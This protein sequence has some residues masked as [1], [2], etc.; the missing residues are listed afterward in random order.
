VVQ[1]D[2]FA[3]AA[4]A[5]RERAFLV[6]LATA[7][8]RREEAD[9]SLDELTGLADAAGASV[10]GRVVQERAVPDA[11]LFLGRG[12]V[13]ELGAPADLVAVADFRDLDRILRPAHADWTLRFAT[14]ELVL[15]HRADSPHAGELA[16]DDWFE[17][18]RRPDVRFGIAAPDQAPAGVATLLCWKLA[19]LHYRPATGSIHAALSA[20]LEPACIR[21][22]VAALMTAL[23]VGEIDY[24]F[25]YRSEAR[26]RG[27]PF[28]ALP[29][30]IHLGDP[31][32]HADYAR[33]SVAVSAGPGRPDETVGGAPIV[34][35]VTITSSPGPISKAPTAA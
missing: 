6:G 34:Y 23:E 16:A 31:A 29:P 14:N 18:L 33:V 15:A 3:V 1:P 26:Q 30:E 5:A 21:S 35:G 11:A 28:R 24:A 25:S 8:M 19:D 9:S 17:I 4:R 22:D 7:R 20:R 32:R 27:V 10:V 2:T 13:A 12:K